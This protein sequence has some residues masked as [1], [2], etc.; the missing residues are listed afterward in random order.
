MVTQA[1]KTPQRSCVACRQKGDKGD[2]LRIVRSPEGSVA[3]DRGG[4][5]PGR[6]AY[7]CHSARCLEAAL[8]SNK[9]ARA[10]R[11]DLTEQDCDDLCRMFAEWEGVTA[12]GGN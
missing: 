3:L 7:I 6:G 2:L 12:H 5:A 10:L 1:H 11:V 4:R 9:L 8:T